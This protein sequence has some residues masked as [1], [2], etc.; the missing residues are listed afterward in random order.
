MARVIVVLAFFIFSNGVA[1]QTEAG[2]FMLGGDISFST[3][4]ED[5]E[6]RFSVSPNIGYFLFNNFA[7]ELK[8]SF[9]MAF[10][11]SGS[12]ERSRGL[13]LAVGARYYITIDNARFRPL[14]LVQHNWG[15]G[16]T[17]NREESITWGKYMLV[18][19]DTFSAG[20]G[21]AYFLTRNFALE[22]LLTYQRIDFEF[23]NANPPIDVDIFEYISLDIG[24][25]FFFSRN[26]KK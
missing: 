14:L 6:R 25:K 1:A 7:L 4:A 20:V 2:S 22:G 9:S 23:K 18:H 24:A 26:S 21:G 5:E 10:Y 8:P 12:L 19:S 17:T 15:R 13:A 16:K 3:L 11:P